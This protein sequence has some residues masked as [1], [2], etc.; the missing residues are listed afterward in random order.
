MK[1]FDER[2]SEQLREIDERGLRRRAREVE[3]PQG[4][5]LIVDGQRVLGLCSNNYLGLAGHPALAASLRSALE[6]E[7]LGSGASR[8]ISGNMAAHRKAEGSLSEFVQQPCAALFSSGYACNVGA[9]QALVDSHDVVFS[10]RL[11]HASLIDGARLSRA[12][13]VVYEHADVSD[14]E[15]KLREHRARGRGAL[16]ITESLFSMDGDLAPLRQ[17]S[18]LASAFDA[19]LVVDEAHALGVLGPQGRGL[20]VELGVHP[21]VTI[22]TLGKSFGLQGAFAAGSEDTVELIRNRARSYIFSTAPAPVLGDVAVSAVRLVREA[23]GLRETLRRRSERLRVG[24]RELG[25]R[26]PEGVGPI[27]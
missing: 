25:Y 21:A 18:A 22:G 15:A 16:V 9:V 19:G 24:L 4:P 27:I 12:K 10:D 26:V 17:I 7:G 5:W 3:G 13:V 14:L 20:C 11:N 8:H 23:D 2:V 1:S 6:T